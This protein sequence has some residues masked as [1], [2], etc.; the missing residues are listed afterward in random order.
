MVIII[1]YD[2]DCVDI[3]HVHIRIEAAFLCLPNLCAWAE[4][5][6]AQGQIPGFSGPLSTSSVR[7]R[8]NLKIYTD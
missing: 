5:T 8:E 7:M 1:Y 4:G 3:L 6:Q 2:L